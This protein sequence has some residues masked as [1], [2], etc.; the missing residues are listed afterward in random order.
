MRGADE[1]RFLGSSISPSSPGSTGLPGPWGPD[2]ENPEVLMSSFVLIGLNSD[3]GFVADAWSEA[4]EN[5]PC[6]VLSR[7]SGRAGKSDDGLAIF[8][9]LVGICKSLAGPQILED[10]N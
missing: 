4:E 6:A 8:A 9:G 1:S 2:N 3:D 7:L 5:C 10:G